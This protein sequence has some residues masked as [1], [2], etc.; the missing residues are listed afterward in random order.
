MPVSAFERRIN[1]SNG[2]VKNIKNSIGPVKQAV[3]FQEFPELNRVWL[4]TGEGEM[5]NRKPEGTTINTV[6][7]GRDNNGSIANGGSILYESGPTQFDKDSAALARQSNVRRILR[8]VVPEQILH[9]PL[10]DIYEFIVENRDRVLYEPNIPQLCEYTCTSPVTVETMSPEI[11]RGDIIAIKK[12]PTKKINNGFRYL[13]DT[14]YLGAVMGFVTDCGNHYLCRSL[15][16]DRFADMKIPKSEV[17][18]VWA[19]VGALKK[20]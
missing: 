18:R 19:I 9:E 20:F 16:P 8:P 4:L 17:Y 14:K 12:M 1:A 10:Q 2:F 15:N 3:I 11:S 5:L 13:L 7:V 6:T